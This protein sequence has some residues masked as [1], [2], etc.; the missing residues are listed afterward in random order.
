MKKVVINLSPQK[1]KA[2]KLDL[3]NLIA[4]LPLLIVVAIVGLAMVLLLQVIA[5][6]K[7]HTYS[8]EAKN[9]QQWESKAK[10]LQDI[11]QQTNNLKTKRDRLDKVLTPR[12]KMSLI[13]GDIFFSLPK[14]IWFQNLDFQEGTLEI[15]GYVVKWNKDFLVSLNDFIRSLR[16]REYFS[17]QFSVVEIKES[18]K[19][20]FNNAEVLKFIV[21]CKK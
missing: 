12:Y 19:E 8:S 10:T 6:K 4:Y 2:M 9:W 15:Q 18:Q 13:L 14:N 16:E 3:G 20:N 11:K 17:S 21:E 7:A 1:Q 5:L